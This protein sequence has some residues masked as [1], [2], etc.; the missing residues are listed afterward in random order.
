VPDSGT[1]Y[2]SSEDYSL[3]RDVA[4]VLVHGHGNEVFD[5]TVVEEHSLV[6]FLSFFE[7][8]LDDVVGV[9]SP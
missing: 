7:D 9:L 1:P 8:L 6:V 3:F 5:E 2:W 4:A